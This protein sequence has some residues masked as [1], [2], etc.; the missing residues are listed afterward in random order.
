MR[1]FGR[2]RDDEPVDPN[3]RSPELGLKFKDL[4]VLGQLIEAGATLVEPRHIVFYSYARDEASAQEMARQAGARGF[5][6][7]VREPL[8]GYPN[9]W[10]VVCETHDVASPEFIRD[11][12]DFFEDLAERYGAEYD[13]WE[14]S[15]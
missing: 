2:K 1:L 9:Q 5:E 3:E 6:S 14:A 8:P 13:G 15:V 11:A 10:S 7:Q 4:A 12:S